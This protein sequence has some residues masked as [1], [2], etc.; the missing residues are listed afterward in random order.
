MSNPAISIKSREYIFDYYNETE[1]AELF[2]KENK[3]LLNIRKDNNEKYVKIGNIWTNDSKEFEKAIKT[4]LSEMNIYC[5]DTKDDKD[6]KN[7][8][9]LMEEYLN[10]TMTT[11]TYEKFIKS[12]KP[13][14]INKTKIKI[15]GI[16][17]AF[18]LNNEYGTDDFTEKLL[19]STK[20]YICYNDGV[21]SL[22]EKKLYDWNDIDIYSTI[23]INR[24]CP[25]NRRVEDDINEVYEIFRGAYKPI[26]YNVLDEN[27][28]SLARALGGHT[29]D[30][31]WLLHKGTRNSSKS[32]EIKMLDCSF[33]GYVNTLNNKYFKC[34]SSNDIAKDNHIFLNKEFVRLL[35]IDN[36]EEL[37]IAN[38]TLIKQINGGDELIC[39]QLYTDELKYIKTNIVLKFYCNTVPTVNNEECLKDAMYIE[40]DYSFIPVIEITDTEKEK[41]QYRLNKMDI[42]TYLNR[43]KY[44]DAFSH[45]IFDN[46]STTKSDKLAKMNYVV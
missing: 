33:N 25:I 31:R 2:I 5:K 23:K 39:R 13:Y 10:G 12:L 16:Y 30:K 17:K 7:T 1:I 41:A 44:Y 34:K 18:L 19:N 9:I 21:Y 38:S 28:K 15:N 37:N 14:N 43:D 36:F 8:N 22:A 20:G 42:T 40:S 6:T 35:L 46:Y 3:H 32:L 26:N 45:I 11:S 24:T 4:L 29:I 27:F